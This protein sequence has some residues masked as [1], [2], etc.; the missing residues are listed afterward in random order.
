MTDLRARGPARP[1]PEQIDALLRGGPCLAARLAVSA[2]ASQP[3]SFPFTRIER[4]G[5][6]A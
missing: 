5:L 2:V 6:P 3:F 1:A 4:P